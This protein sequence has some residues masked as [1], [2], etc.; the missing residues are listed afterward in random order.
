[1]SKIIRIILFFTDKT[2]N[3]SNKKSSTSYNDKLSDCKTNFRAPVSRFAV[4]FSFKMSPILRQNM[5][6]VPY[7]MMIL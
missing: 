4:Y 6:S 1:M 2:I 5:S 7:F 3:D